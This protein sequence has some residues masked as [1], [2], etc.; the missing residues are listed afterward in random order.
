MLHACVV[1]LIIAS[2]RKPFGGLYDVHAHDFG[3]VLQICFP[4]GGDPFRGRL[5]DVMDDRIV[6]LIVDVDVQRANKAV[7]QSACV[8]SLPMP[9]L[10]QKM[11]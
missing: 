3:F 8:T 1:W 5:R 11:R 10:K 9:S 2:L 7:P 6:E 4:H